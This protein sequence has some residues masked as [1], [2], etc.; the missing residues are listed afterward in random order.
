MLP[1]CHAAIILLIHCNTPSCSCSSAPPHRPLCVASQRASGGCSLMG[2][3]GTGWVRSAARAWRRRRDTKAWPCARRRAAKGWHAAG[4]RMREGGAGAAASRGWRSQRRQGPG[5]Q[6]EKEG[7]GGRGVQLLQGTRG[8]EGDTVQLQRRAERNKAS[9]PI[10]K[11]GGD[12][13][14]ARGP[15]RGCWQFTSLAGCL[16]GWRLGCSGRAGQRHGAASLAAGLALAACG[17]GADAGRGFALAR[18]PRSL[19]LSQV[20]YICG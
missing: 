9:R 15:T 16:A 10:L 1:A 6:G 14:R 4:A 18:R 3:Q 17:Q 20:D 12:K 13:G 11:A 2:R 19:L 7:E 5:V 8:R